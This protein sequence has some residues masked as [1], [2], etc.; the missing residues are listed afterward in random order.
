M[1]IPFW[2]GGITSGRKGRTNHRKIL[3]LQTLESREVP[4]L[5]PT[6]AE[7]EMLELINQL[8]TAPQDQYAR[9][10]SSNDADVNSAL[11]FFGVNL[12]TLR[13]Q[14]NALTPVQPL[15]WNDN[16]MTSSA[17]HN[18]A[19]IAADTQSHQ[20]PGE[21]DLGSRATSAGYAGWTNIAENIYAYSESTFY[22]HAGFAIDWGGSS[23]TGGI[24]SP[25]GHR[26]NM[27]S[28]SY[29]EVGI[30][31]T[32]ESNP[33]T[34]VGPQVITEDFGNRSGLSG[35]GY[36]LGVVFKDL[37]ANTFYNAGEGLGNVNIQ[38]AEAGGFNRT[39]TSMTAGGYQTFLNSGTYTVTYSGG[40]LASP[41]TRT[42]TIGS[43]NVKV[44]VVSGVTASQNSAPVLNITPV[45]TLP[46][47]ATGNS[48]P[49]GTAVSA[50]IAG[51]VTDANPSNTIGIAVTAMTGPPGGNWQF[52]T[53]NGGTWANFGTVST[54][55]A[56]LLPPT[57]LV[58]FVP[59][60]SFAG[61][62]T[63]SYKAWDGTAGTPGSTGSVTPAGGS[64][65]FSTATETTTVRVQTAPV[66]D[67]T[68]LGVFPAIAEDAV[69]PGTTINTLLGKSFVDPNSV[70]TNGVAITALSNT[71]DGTW[72]YRYSGST[73]WT[74]IGA[75]SQANAFLLR[76]AD[77]IRFLPGRN[78]NGTVSISF[79]AWDRSQGTLAGRWD[80][81]NAAN[82]GGG[83]AFS[84]QLVTMSQTI[85]PVNDAP[86]LNITPSPTLAPVSGPIG[87]ITQTTVAAL[88]GSS[89]TDVDA[90]AVR[91]MAIIGVTRSTAYVWEYSTDGGT[92]WLNLSLASVTSARL[93]R[94]TDLIRV[95]TLTA[96][97]NPLAARIIFR[98]WD[99]TQ[100]TAG[101]MYNIST[102]A[103]FG[104]TTAFSLAA[105][106]ATTTVG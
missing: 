47:I 35:G 73:T 104:G 16:L 29:R 80:V 25:P 88:L 57:A 83:T 56:R 37:N 45:Q 14:W 50:L 12:T 24:Q 87:S 22:G 31:I 11:S 40:G 3:G 9:L 1:K 18:N 91:G 53:D 106:A 10:V 100:G 67:A 76:G 36:L 86:V 68:K 55:S 49:T 84:T 103:R 89:V 6:G 66:L 17:N 42:V 97:A 70:T 26:N 65:A 32:D 58:R 34:D 81:S 39:L 69:P 59:V 72:Q 23:A 8:R 64:T 95:R 61:A 43:A 13:S 51:V 38:V 96:V 75:V 74:N 93:L 102:S 2:R 98:A 77:Y 105:D 52:S 46:P 27:M 7:Q 33:N 4:A 41:V 101:G 92:T 71:A 94:D 85:N 63:L 78:F 82:I 19:M 5:N 48:N 90:G 15:A 99:Q 30:T 54:T 28:G 79:R 60:A 44:D 21:Q 62:A 20:L